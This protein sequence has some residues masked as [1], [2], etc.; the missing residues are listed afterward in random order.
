MNR[1][2]AELIRKKLRGALGEE[3]WELFETLQRYSLE[4]LE[5]NFPRNNLERDHM[6]HVGDKVIRNPATW[7]RGE[8]DFWGRGNGVGIVI[9]PPFGLR[10]GSVYVAWPLG[11]SFE[12]VD[13]LLP[14]PM[15]Y[16]DGA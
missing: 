10:E 11:H 13:Q 12:K 6:F 3:E 8:S 5:R 14:A 4:E 15:E 9:D 2:R 16:S 7:Q 1:K